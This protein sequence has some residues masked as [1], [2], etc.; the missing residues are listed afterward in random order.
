MHKPYKL[1]PE[2]PYSL[3]VTVRA[4]KVE[5]FYNQVV[6]KY[7]TQLEVLRPVIDIPVRT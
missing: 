5:D 3:I 4:K 1:S 6:R 2:L 7:A